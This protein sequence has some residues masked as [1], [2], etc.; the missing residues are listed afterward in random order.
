MTFQPTRR[1]MQNLVNLGR[2]LNGSRQSDRGGYQPTE[3]LF[4]RISRNVFLGWL[5]A[6]VVYCFLTSILNLL[7][8]SRSS[9]VTSDLDN[10]AVF[11]PHGLVNRIGGHSKIFRENRHQLNQP[12]GIQD[13]GQW[14]VGITG[15]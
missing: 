2:G 10:G 11:P 15:L 7:G 13:F 8:Q 1:S 14:N 6:A 12:H 9:Q 3:R 5:L 4:V